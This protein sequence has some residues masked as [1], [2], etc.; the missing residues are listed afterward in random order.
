MKTILKSLVSLVVLLTI[1][2]TQWA[3]AQATIPGEAVANQTWTLIPYVSNGGS[4]TVGPYSIGVT[5]TGGASS[6]DADKATALA[7][8]SLTWTFS[9]PIS[10]IQISTTF[11]ED[12]QGEDETVT[13]TGYDSNNQPVGSDTWT[14][15]NV[16]SR[17]LNFSSPA[18]SVIVSQVFSRAP[19]GGTA[20]YGY[21]D[22]TV[23][24]TE[25]EAFSTQLSRNNGQPGFRMANE[26]ILGSAGNGVNPL[27][28]EVTFSVGQG[29]V[30]TIP[31]GSFRVDAPGIWSYT[32]VPQSK[33]DPIIKVTL[34][35]LGTRMFAWSSSVTQ[36]AIEAKKSVVTVTITIGDD[37]GTMNTVLI[38]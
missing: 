19:A 17:Q 26:F 27:T 36:T 30:H 24:P 21:V 33:R 13:V 38:K 10:S 15:V 6:F 25:F 20:V 28:E 34:T 8:G 22:T 5:L 37:S 14:N 32:S 11:Q 7:N 31:A 1:T 23:G 16:T 18:T 12:A 2:S 29:F 9:Q 4:T 35:Q 3:I